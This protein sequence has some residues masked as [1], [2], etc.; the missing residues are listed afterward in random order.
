MD[1]VAVTTLDFHPRTRI[2]FGTGTL[3][4]LGKLVREYGGRR[5]LLVTD[6]GI[7]R[8]GH[9]ERAVRSIKASGIDV[10]TF[11]HVFENPTTL[12]VDECVSFARRH[13]IDFLVGLGGGSSLDTAK[14]CNFL[15][16]GGGRMEDYWGVGKATKPMLPLIAVPTTAGT[17]SECQ[18][19]ALISQ[20]D[21]HVKMACGDPKAAA[22]VALLDPELTLTQPRE[23][24][25]A[26]GMDALAHAVESA[27]TRRRSPISEMLSREAF[28]LCASGLS[29]VFSEPSDIQARGNVLLGAAL[30]GMAIEN[31]MLGAA[32]AAANPLTAH[33]GV[34]HGEAVGLLLPHVVRFNGEDPEAG[35]IY[36]QLALAAGLVDDRRDVRPA[37]EALAEYLHGYLVTAG[38]PTS[39][40]AMGIR[41]PDYDLLAGDAAR[42]WT[43]QFNPRAVENVDFLR[44]YRSV[45]QNGRADTAHNQI[46]VP[47]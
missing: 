17:G 13:Q 10:V 46:E 8:A 28:R 3:D 12:V 23:V 6:V 25:A 43:A 20:A 38:L 42:Q 19:Y 27:V 4:R 39:L 21:T 26:T 29:R 41:E 5:A 34:I 14:G 33:F 40:A 24:A 47:R 35:R 9:A 16:T 32:H 37:V 22:R 44:L 1:S 7:I 11:D 2:V 18:S 30:G 45:S 31:S 15:L 36:Q